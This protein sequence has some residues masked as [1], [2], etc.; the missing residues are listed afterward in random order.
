MI[1]WLVTFKIL[2]NFAKYCVQE[3]KKLARK[4]KEAQAAV[5][6]G[7]GKERQR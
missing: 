5:K 4:A 1:T 3:L 7:K 2:R 6:R